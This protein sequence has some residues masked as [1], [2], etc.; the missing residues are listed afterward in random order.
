MGVNK[1]QHFGGKLMRKS[2]LLVVLVAALSVVLAACNMTGTPTPAATE[3]NAATYLPGTDVLSGYTITEAASITEAIT[4][5][6]ETGADALSNPA[7]SAAITRVD[8]FIACY[9]ETG[10][11]AANIYTQTDLAGIL[12]GGSLVPGA[13][14]VAVVN[15][16]LVA[17]N[18]V[19][20]A[21][22][23]GF[24]AQ[25]A[26]EICQ[27]NG[28]FTAAGD[29]FRYIYIATKADFC[30]SVESHFAAAGS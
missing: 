30:S 29:T 21:T 8:A 6:A 17:E 18:F 27:G 25:S 3:N 5:V 22:S 23:S 4:S 13:G 20:C 12:S 16:D 11:V 10:A 24:S 9:Q 1:F 19:A 14:A 26:T 15:Q 2:L 28:S 7:I